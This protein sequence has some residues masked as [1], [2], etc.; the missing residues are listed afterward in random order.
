MLSSNLT[1]K[2]RG[3]TKTEDSQMQ[4]ETMLPSYAIY[5]LRNHGLFDT[6]L[7][8]YSE[9][10]L[11]DEAAIK[12]KLSTHKKLSDPKE[13]YNLFYSMAYSFP[14][15]ED[16]RAGD[17]INLI[18]FDVEN[19]SQADAPGACKVV[20]KAVGLDYA[21]CSSI[22]SGNGIHVIAWI[23]NKQSLWS[24]DVK[25]FKDNRLAYKQWVLKIKTALSD[26][27]LDDAKVDSTAF[28]HKKVMRLPFTINRKDVD[29]QAYGIQ[30]NIEGQELEFPKIEDSKP[31]KK[32]GKLD[33]DSIIE[34]CAFVQHALTKPEDFHEPEARTFLQ[35]VGVIEG[36][37]EFAKE[38][39]KKF[40][41]SPSVMKEVHKGDID[42]KLDDAIA[43]LGPGHKRCETVNLLDNWEK[44]AQCPYYDKVEHPAEIKT[45]D[46][47]S[48]EEIGFTSKHVSKTGKVSY[49]RHYEDIQKVMSRDYHYKIFHKRNFIY[50][51]E[52]G[53]YHCVG[54]DYMR[55]LI[56][57]KVTVEKGGA[58]LTQREMG[59]AMNVLS[60]YNQHN[61]LANF[62]HGHEENHTNFTNG[63]VD[64]TTL[65]FKEH[66]P[67]YNFVWQI[68]HDWP[69]KDVPTPKY[70]EFMKRIMMGDMELVQLL[71]EYIGYILS[72][73]VYDFQNFM[74]WWGDGDNG[75][76]SLVN[77][78]KY[79]IGTENLA[80][81]RYDSLKEDKFC[82]AE[83]DGKLGN[84]ADDESP[85]AFLNSSYL[86]QISGNTPIRA[87]GVYAREANSFTNRAKVIMSFNQLP[88]LPD[89]SQGMLR[90]P[91]WIP[92][93]YNIKKDKKLKRNPKFLKE[94]IFPEASGIIRKCL[95]RFS[96][97]METSKFTTPNKSIEL[98]RKVLHYSSP[99]EAWYGNHVRLG[100]GTKFESG[101]LY[102]WF[103]E[104][105]YGQD[106]PANKKVSHSSFSR[107]MQE[108]LDRDAE[109]KG[110]FYKRGTG[111][112]LVFC[113]IQVVNRE[114]DIE[115]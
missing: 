90:R 26:A 39:Y 55:S 11:F 80:F 106:I 29:K 9:R 73:H 111:N 78:I 14:T 68:P 103:N 63:V 50:Y 24:S 12:Q 64:F 115:I 104:D 3:P 19:V 17:G 66:K 35:I 77:L 82:K 71:E 38:H 32:Y 81:I 79:L 57:D 61:D 88:H 40:T 84:I 43:G 108:K 54:S 7:R 99:F 45:R 10:D 8:L 49:T 56:N 75:K 96:S 44:C 89:T 47:I 15:T 85:K 92:F 102:A 2:T 21:K 36:K 114:Q 34:G 107:K 83:L 100:K 53:L 42:K 98:G 28:G 101:Q 97:V 74:C 69:K 105:S 52:D 112:K 70:D 113:N 41:S 16:P 94:D 72:G 31:R 95:K 23:E 18:A 5:W 109:F 76:T 48:T 1:K 67:V 30:N 4:K 33:G 22:Y 27:G 86:K 91:I 20:A 25:F 37:E 58:V 46:F 60:Y 87:R 51:Y 110:E 93:D 62:I 6:K 59:E 65:E 13:Q